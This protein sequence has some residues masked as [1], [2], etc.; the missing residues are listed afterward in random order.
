MIGTIRR[1]VRATLPAKSRDRIWV[2]RQYVRRYGLIAGLRTLNRVS[3]ARSG[4]LLVRIPNSKIPVLL[5]ANTS[6]GE[7][8]EE[9][10]VHEQY[11]LSLN[12]SPKLIVD[13][14]AN[15]GYASVYFANKYPKA[16][17]IAI[18]PEASNFEM[19]KQNAASYPNI[20]I[21]QCGIWNKRTT[22][23]IENP[24]DENNA[25]RVIESERAEGNGN[26]IEAIT[27]QDIL[28]SSGV[29]FIDILKLDIEGA[30]KEVFEDKNENTHMWLDRVG[31]LVVELHDRFRSGCSEAFYS[32]VSKRDFKE[33]QKGQNTIMTRDL[34]LANLS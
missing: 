10:F 30:E 5:R 33:H 22:L 3:K 31:V 18:E 12:K 16:Q 13:G 28:D 26:F 14:G 2:I 15:V 8:F 20:K 29:D 11:D 6:D 4:T 32:A 24:Q 7:T 34:T 9:I 23:R 21:L 19:L 25:F 17:V 1:I 27:I